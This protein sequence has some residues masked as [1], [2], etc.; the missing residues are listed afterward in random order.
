MP[1]ATAGAAVHAGLHW[2]GEGQPRDGGVYGE[3][4][5]SVLALRFAPSGSITSVL[6]VVNRL[7]PR[8]GAF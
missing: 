4:Q 2:S 8:V 7:A 3:R 5:V 6:P 1:P